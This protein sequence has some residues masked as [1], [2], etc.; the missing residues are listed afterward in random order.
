MKPK[1]RLCSSYTDG[2]I[3]DNNDQVNTYIKHKAIFIKK[4]K[5]RK[6]SR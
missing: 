6:L 3:I 5:R 2:I 1:Y 4:I